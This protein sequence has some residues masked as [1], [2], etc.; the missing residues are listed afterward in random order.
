M[1]AWLI[2]AAVIL[3]A[4]SGAPGVLADRRGR[5]CERLAVWLMVLGAACGCAG[6]LLGALGMGS[7]LAAAWPVPGGSLSV[8]VDAISGMFA[9]Q[10]SVVTALGAVYGLEYWSQAG[11]PQNA[12]KLRAF[13]GVTTAGLLLIVIARN[14]MLFLFAWEL[15]A[16]G[17]F[18]TITT[19]DEKPLVREVGYVYLLATRIGTLALFAMFALLFAASGTLDVDGWAAAMSSGTA[20]AIF[21][22][23][24]VGF[25]LKAGV[26]PLHVWL[27]GAHANAPS[28]VSA[29]MSGSLIKIGI[30]GL[31]RITALCAHPPMWWGI[32]V[33]VAG[34]ISGVLGVAFAIG[35]HDL[36]R[37]LAYHS[38]ENIGIIC[39]GLGVALIGRSTG[40]VDLEVLGLAGALLHV[41]NHGLF[42]A[43][44]FL[45]AGSVLHATGTRDI[46]RLG[47]L[48]RRMPRTALAFLIGAVAIC[49]LPPL[50]GLVSELLVYIGLF[51]SVTDTG[52][53]SWLACAFAA[54]ALALIGGL[55]LACFAKAFGAVFLGA[56]RTAAGEHAHD[57]GGTMLAPMAALAACCLFIGLGAPL[58]APLLDQAIAAWSGDPA[59]RLV[60]LAPLT[61]VALVA[62]GLLIALALAARAI[63]TTRRVPATVGT[64]DCGYASP[65]ARMQYTASSFA[66]TLVSMLAWALRPARH[67]TTPSGVFPASA[68]VETHVPD[69][70]LDRGLRPAF[71]LAGRYLGR[72]MFI[73]RGSVHAYLL[74]ILGALIVLLLWR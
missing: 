29:M 32:A 24:L 54:P 47:G 40:R 7:E 18:L 73:Q 69:V 63:R 26:M 28:H 19:E 3:T 46:D 50:N 37:L 60:T 10:I 66:D 39:I 49:G 33:L 72:F 16:V 34:T 21:V 30:Y 56:P 59:P 6:G 51:R 35:Q 4:A 42:K 68:R 64:W 25:G 53:T 12:R 22:L 45:S 67:V 58:I 55:A 15:M 1:S 14:A 23:A 57:P 38:V 11:H 8:G 20:D 17:A 36:K 65:S 43:L 13:Y 74:Y 31:V 2:V 27:P 41:W 48:W 9:I 61:A 52:G 44:L 71:A 70:V 62:G 5:A